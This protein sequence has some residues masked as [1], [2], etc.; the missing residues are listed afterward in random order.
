MQR[1]VGWHDCTCEVRERSLM[2]VHSEQILEVVASLI[3]VHLET[4]SFFV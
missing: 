4:G 2:E 1:I 3:N